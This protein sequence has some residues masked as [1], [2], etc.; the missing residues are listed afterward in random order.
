M[1]FWKN[2]RSRMNLYRQNIL[3]PHQIPISLH[4]NVA[5]RPDYRLRTNLCR[6]HRSQRLHKRLQRPLYLTKAVKKELE[7]NDEGRCQI[8]NEFRNVGIGSCAL[9]VVVDWPSSSVHIS[10]P[11][12]LETG[13]E[14]QLQLVFELFTLI[15]TLPSDLKRGNSLNGDESCKN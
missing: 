8:S 3:P 4:F 13:H 15:F 14:N 11:V 5:S 12:S 6:L 1:T 2:A 7:T 10:K 9:W